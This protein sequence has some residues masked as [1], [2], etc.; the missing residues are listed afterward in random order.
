MVGKEGQRHRRK[1]RAVKLVVKIFEITLLFILIGLSSLL[2]QYFIDA[3]WEMPPLEMYFALAVSIL[4]WIFISSVHSFNGIPRVHRYRSLFFR[5]GK[6]HFLNMVLLIG[7]KYLFWIDSLPLLFLI[8]YSFL[9]FFVMFTLKAYVYKLF[10]VIRTRGYDVQNVLVITDAGY[11]PLID[12]I[13]TARQHGIRIAAIQTESLLIALRYKNLTQIFSTGKNVR[14]ILDENVIDEVFLFKSSITNEEYHG[15]ISICNEIGVILRTQT[16]MPIFEE[17]LSE[18]KPANGTPFLS[19]VDNDSGKLALIVKKMSDYYISLIALVMLFPVIIAIAVAIK[20]DSKGPVFFRQKRVGRRGR[21]F[22]LLKFRT[23]RVDAEQML[24]QLKSQNEADGPA[25]KI[26]NDIRI[27]RI[28]K[29][30][31]R[32]GLDEVPQFINVLR[33]EM[34]LIGPRPPLPSEVEKYEPWQVRR[35]SVNPGITC[36]W[37]VAPNRNQIKFDKWMQLDL[38]YIDSWSLEK[39]FVLMFRTVGTFFKASGS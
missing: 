36:S 11:E 8:I 24:E 23:M 18:L 7:I 2:Y 37:Q 19:L 3:S 21:H 25:F 9:G 26:K 15:L 6:L 35:L 17:H 10:R 34:S 5:C 29:I 39:D 33:G 13:L 14:S 12:E 27:T 38:Q 22:M 1:N 31:R 28:G 32:V 30:I 20:V 16:E 4:S